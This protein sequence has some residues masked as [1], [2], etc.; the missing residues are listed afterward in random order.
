MYRLYN[1]L[2]SVGFI[3]FKTPLWLY[4]VAPSW[5]FGDFPVWI[6]GCFGTLTF[7]L[8]IGILL[9]TVTSLSFVIFRLSRPR[10][11]EL[12]NLQNTELYFN[13][14]SLEDLQSHVIKEDVLALRF[15]APFVFSNSKYVKKAIEN[16]Y[17]TSDHKEQIKSV[18]M[19]MQGVNYIDSST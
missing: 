13:R 3:R 9:A 7:G 12:A 4:R 5:K 11:V 2:S 10:M 17:E 16:A 1:N 6:V 18:A 14:Q 15:E 19:D 8:H